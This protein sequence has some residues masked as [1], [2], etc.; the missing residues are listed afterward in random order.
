[1]ALHLFL[2]QLSEDTSEG[3]L[4]CLVNLCVMTHWSLS[5]YFA[6]SHPETLWGVGLS[7]GEPV[8]YDTLALHSF[9]PWPSKDTS[10]GGL[11]CVVGLHVTMC[12]TLSIFLPAVQRHSGRWIH[13]LGKSLC[14]VLATCLFHPSMEVGFVCITCQSPMWGEPVHTTRLW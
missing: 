12:W 11:V 10:E 8:H 9:L 4:I 6:P 3:G 2:P 13:L 14:G 7:L 1:M 5:I